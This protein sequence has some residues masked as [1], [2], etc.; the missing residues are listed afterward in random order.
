MRLEVDSNQ[1][2]IINEPGKFDTVLKFLTRSKDHEDANI[3]GWIP[4]TGTGNSVTDLRA[5]ANDADN[6]TQLADLQTAIH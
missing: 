2:E 4:D 5:I 3:E 6:A 1:L